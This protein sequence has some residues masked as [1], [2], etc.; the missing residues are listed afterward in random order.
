MSATQSPPAVPHPTL[1]GS[2]TSLSCR[3]CGEQYPIG[4]R[5]ACEMCFGPLEV[6]YDYT[7]VSR[8]SIEAGPQNI[9]RYK[10]LL[11]V[12]SNVAETP[13]LEPA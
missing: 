10:Q 4:P 3:E 9:W 5:Y 12:P 8:E 13:N 11:P 1:L 7:G 2:A 6:A